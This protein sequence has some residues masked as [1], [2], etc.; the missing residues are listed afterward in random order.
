MSVLPLRADMLRVGIDVS[1]VPPSDIATRWV[2][3]DRAARYQSRRVESNTQTI[4]KM[5][6]GPLEAWRNPTPHP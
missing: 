5:E 1:K 3:V 6:H 4:K 2:H